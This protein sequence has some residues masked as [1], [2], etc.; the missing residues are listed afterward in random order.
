MA[1]KTQKLHK[2]RA[3]QIGRLHGR[4]E[5]FFHATKNDLRAAG[6]IEDT[7]K[8]LGIPALLIALTI[9]LPL[10]LGTLHAITAVNEWL[11]E[12]KLTMEDLDWHF[13]D[14]DEEEA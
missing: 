2:T 3:Y 12:N 13:E 11:A 10:R 4:L 14:D 7:A 1:T 6:V 5:G 9:S 8:F